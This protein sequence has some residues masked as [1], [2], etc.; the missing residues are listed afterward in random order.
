MYLERKTDE[1]SKKLLVQASKFLFL[2][3]HRFE[4]LARGIF[5]KTLMAITK[6]LR[7]AVYVIKPSGEQITPRDITNYHQ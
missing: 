4:L 5:E 1:D 2:I 6:R 7:N 3:N